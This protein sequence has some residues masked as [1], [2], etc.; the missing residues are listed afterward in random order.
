MP[1]ALCFS[2]YEFPRTLADPLRG[3]LA[4]LRRDTDPACNIFP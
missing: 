3:F 2:A 4:L 1:A